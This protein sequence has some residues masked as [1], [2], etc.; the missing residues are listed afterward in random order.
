MIL[1]KNDLVRMHGYFAVE[2]M[3]GRY[4]FSSSS[5]A[6]RNGGQH[7]QK[8]GDGSPL[9]RASLGQT[10]ASLTKWAKRKREGK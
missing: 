10:S 8:E 9:V 1:A 3:S 6:I 5:L 7:E 2:V 4:N